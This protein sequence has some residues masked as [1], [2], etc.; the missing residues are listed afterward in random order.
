MTQPPNGFESLVRTSPYLELLGPLFNSRRGKELVLGFF[1]QEKHCNARGLVHGGVF[2]SVA[3]VALGYSAALSG[4]DSVPMVTA[5]L[6][7]DYAGSAK[8]GDWIE[9]HTDVQ[10]VG[11][12]M[13]YANA[14]F[15]VKERRIVRAS[16]VFSVTNTD[17][18]KKPD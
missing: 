5:S 14:Y 2:S 3:D 13:A 15:S 10:H 9:V 16:A 12:R 11:R 1:A 18:S 7:V 8:L 4:E 17:S 6:N